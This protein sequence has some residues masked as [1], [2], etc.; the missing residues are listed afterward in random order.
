MRILKEK[1]GSV[2]AFSVALIGLFATASSAQTDGSALTADDL[3]CRAGLEKVSGNYQK[4]ATSTRQRCLRRIFSGQQAAATDCIAGQGD[5]KTAERLSDLDDRV[6]ARLPRKCTGANLE[7][8]GFP[9]VCQDTVSPPGVFD[10]NDLSRCVIDRNDEII[11][12]M[13]EQEYPPEIFVPSRYVK[14]INGVG[15]KANGMVASAVAARSECSVRD[16]R[17]PFFS[18][19]CRQEMIPYGPGTADERTNDRVINSYVT[20]LGGMPRS[21]ATVN[22][23]L[24]DYTDDCTDETGGAFTAFDLKLCLFDSHRGF[25]DDVVDISFPPGPACGNGIVEGEEVC[26]DGN[27]V[28]TDAC[29]SSCED[30]FCGDGI[31]HDGVEEC[32]DGN[33]DNTDGCST[34]CRLASCGDGIVQGGEDCDDGNTVDS[35]SCRADCSAAACGDG[36]VCISLDCSTG[37][38]GGPE[39]CDDGGTAAGDG[40]SD[41]CGIEFCGDGVVNNNNEECDDGIDNGSGPNQCRLGS[42]ELPAC[43]DG[44]VDDAPEFGE[45][46]DPPDGTLCDASCKLLSCGNGV[47]DEGEECDDGTGNS[48]T[49]PDACRTDCTAAGCGDMVIDGG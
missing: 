9:G 42:C 13:L 16:E 45:T 5:A 43:G 48:N 7:E 39:D 22:L 34:N 2:L 36:V 11:A 6:S 41:V 25:I 26:D 27:D 30:A 47:L 14:C 31:V 38:T 28:D 49:T 19:D 23:D 37:P 18:L 20:L 33:S 44:I 24:L 21:C 15:R 10:V 46:C 4:K 1:R 32:D 40:C 29:T 17:D 3:A 8:L 12:E 35:D